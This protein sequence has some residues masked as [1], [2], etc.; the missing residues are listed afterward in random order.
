METVIIKRA[1]HQ[2]D[3]S[4][5]VLGRVATEVANLLRGKNKVGFTYH[6]D[7]GDFVTVS[8]V[9]KIVVTGRKAT[10]KMYYRHSGYPGGITSKTYEELIE[11]KPTEALRLAV[12][13]M[14]PDNRLRAKWM[15]R[16]KLEVGTNGK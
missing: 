5:R 2:I 1:H 13:S 7:L 3:A 11:R 15:A 8:N 6:Q 9:D 14:L 10:N 12:R 4:D 16:L